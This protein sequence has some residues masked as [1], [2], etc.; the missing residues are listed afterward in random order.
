ME[1]LSTASGIFFADDGEREGLALGCWGNCEHIRWWCGSNLFSFSFGCWFGQQDALYCCAHPATSHFAEYAFDRSFSAGLA[2][3][4]LPPRR[5]ENSTPQ[6]R[7]A[8]NVTIRCIGPSVLSACKRSR[9]AAD[10]PSGGL[11]SSHVQ[12]R[13][14]CLCDIQRKSSISALSLQETK[15]EMSISSQD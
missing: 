14:V 3:H 12:C 13:I 8:R 9:A 11:Q 1:R 10:R 6:R 4:A 2:Q 7:N 5:R 15:C